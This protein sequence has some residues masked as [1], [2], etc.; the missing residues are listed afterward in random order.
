MPFPCLNIFPAS[1]PLCLPASLSSPASLP[2]PRLPCLSPYPAS[3]PP[4]L[5]F[6][7]PPLPHYLSLASLALV[8]TLPPCLPC[9]FFYLLSPSLPH[10]LNITL[11]SCLS[12]LPFTS[13]PYLPLPPVPCYCQR[14]SPCHPL[15][16]ALPPHPTIV[17]SHLEWLPSLA[18]A[19]GITEAGRV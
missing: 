2:L 11:S 1:L 9:Q 19:S 12:P 18:P 14:P 3:L 5:L 15:P 7:F 4:C 16:G 13:L 8:F 6:L 10:T 17:A